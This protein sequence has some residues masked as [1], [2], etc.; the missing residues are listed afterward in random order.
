MLMNGLMSIH[1]TCSVF[2]PEFQS[3]N[4]QNNNNTVFSMPRNVGLI[5]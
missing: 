3:F 4:W 2:A 5:P 1:S